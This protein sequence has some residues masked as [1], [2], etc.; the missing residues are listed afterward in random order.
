[1]FISVTQS[2]SQSALSTSC[3]LQPSGHCMPMPVVCSV[4]RPSRFLRIR[5]ALVFF[6]NLPQLMAGNLMDEGIA[7][8]SDRNYQV[9][10]LPG[11]NVF[12]CDS[13]DQVSVPDLLQ[14]VC[15]PLDVKVVKSASIIFDVHLGIF[16]CVS[17]NVIGQHVA[18][19]NLAELPPPLAFA[20]IPPE[21]SKVDIIIHNTGDD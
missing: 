11:P 5:F 6:Y 9:R 14:G 17:A 1:M 8:V 16:E 20:N 7:K 12:T 15:R 2:H 4:S 19:G 10:V 3:L 13:I 18:K 21:T